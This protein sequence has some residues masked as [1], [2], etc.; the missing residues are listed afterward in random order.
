MDSSSALFP[1]LTNTRVQHLSGARRQPDQRW[2]RLG[3]HGR[4]RRLY[5]TGGDVA[6][7]RNPSISSSL[8]SDTH[9]RPLNKCGVTCK[10][11]AATKTRVLTHFDQWISRTLN[12][13]SMTKRKSRYKH[14]KFRKCRLV[15][16]ASFFKKHIQ[17][18]KLGVN[19]NIFP[20]LFQ[21]FYDLS[22]FPLLVQAWK[23]PF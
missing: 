17:Y 11:A 5:G 6:S 10:S 2:W 22:F 1:T 19:Y 13:I 15:F 18:F 16:W 21:N 14:D 12:Q 23:W 9:P 7:G 3:E 20:W 8:D 4:E